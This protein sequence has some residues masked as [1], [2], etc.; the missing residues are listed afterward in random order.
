[1]T[2]FLNV[3]LIIFLQ[4]NNTLYCPKHQ[5]N[6]VWVISFN[7]INFFTWQYQILWILSQQSLNQFYFLPCSLAPASVEYVTIYNLNNHSILPKSFCRRPPISTLSRSGTHWLHICL[8]K[9]HVLIDIPS[10][11]IIPK[12]KSKIFSTDTKHFS[13]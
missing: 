5:K 1:M 10:F 3:N 13:A 7:S 2:L 11:P 12:V 4:R 9:V 8:P 6:R